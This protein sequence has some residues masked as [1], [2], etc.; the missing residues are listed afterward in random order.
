MTESHLTLVKRYDYERYL[1]T[2]FTPVN[3]RPFLWALYAFN[4]EIAKTREVTTQ[5]MIGLIRL[6]WWRDAIKRL[7]Q[8]KAD[9][10]DVIMALD[11][12]LKTGIEW[13]ENDFQILIDARE[14]DVYDDIMLED[15]F[16]NYCL[17]TSAPLLRLAMK[18]T[19]ETE[20]DTSVESIAQSYA[21]VGLLR[22][23]SLHRAQ[24]KNFLPDISIEKIAAAIEQKLVVKP[25]AKTPLLFYHV[26]QINLKKLKRAEFNTADMRFIRSDPLLALKLAVKMWFCT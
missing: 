20:D 24:G 5:S 16:W 1:T 17:M 6:Q 25:Q 15:E 12:G 26:I 10:H 7:F 21:A 4:L 23:S 14:R 22:A 18:A 13:N 3:A 19:H 9:K 8:G 11:D 2:L